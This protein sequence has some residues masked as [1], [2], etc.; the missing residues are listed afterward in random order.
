M[1]GWSVHHDYEAER[2][3]L[4]AQDP[5]FLVD[6]VSRGGLVSEIT[7]GMDVS[8][9][10][11]LVLLVARMDRARA[12]GLESALVRTTADL[13]T[14]RKDLAEF[15]RELGIE[16]QDHAAEIAELNAVV[17]AQARRLATLEGET[18]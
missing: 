9:Y 8:A 6:Y 12:T 17:V 18:K 2:V 3:T 4:S 7:I 16:R 14:A 1:N 13:L 11:S 5:S 10:Q 15:H